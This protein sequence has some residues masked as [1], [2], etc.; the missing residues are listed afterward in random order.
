[1]N[2]NQPANTAGKPTS[3]KSEPIQDRSK[4]LSERKSNSSIAS[5]GLLMGVNPKVIEMF[6][7]AMI[8]AT[9][10]YNEQNK[11]K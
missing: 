4:I 7:P 3:L 10:T 2:M 5:A 9:K 1:M 11:T 6:L 8:E